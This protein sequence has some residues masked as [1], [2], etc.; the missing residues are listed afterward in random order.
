MADADNFTL[1]QPG[2]LLTPSEAGLICEMHMLVIEV[3]FS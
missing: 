3:M 1:R 2:C